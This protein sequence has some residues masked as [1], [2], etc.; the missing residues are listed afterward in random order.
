MKNE[1]LATARKL[2][3]AV[4][5][6]H[7]GKEVIPLSNTGDQHRPTLTLRQ[8]RCVERLKDE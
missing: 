4:P 6:D 1:T 7:I 3:A 2:I 5:G 8:A